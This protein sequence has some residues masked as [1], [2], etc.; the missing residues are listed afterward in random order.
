VVCAAHAWTPLQSSDGTELSWPAEAWPLTLA[1]AGATWSRAA[2]AWTQA[3]DVGFAPAADGLVSLRRIEDADEWADVVGDPGL[4]AFTL[5]TAEGG[6]LLDADVVLNAARFRFA[7]PPEPRAQ[8]T[9]TVLLHE[10]GHVLGLGHSCGDG[11]APGCFGL[12]ADDPRFTAV[13]FPSI[14]PGELRAPGADDVEGLTAQVDYPLEV[15]RP[16][17]TAVEA[18][19]PGRWRI[20]VAGGHLL[21]VRR[22]DALVRA[23][24]VADADGV[25]VRTG[26]AGPLTLE[27]WS[28]A[29]QGWVGVDALEPAAVGLDAAGVGAEATDPVPS[30][31]GDDGCAATGVAASAML[32][33]AL[34]V[35]RRE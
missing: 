35:R 32:W 5:V 34:A 6:V 12:D 26:D 2:A 20:E 33:L 10:L 21:R 17:V 22:G 11:G 19:G 15:D 27:V 16:V 7:D 31:G 28:A 1:E 29:G 24:L 23:T 4:V 18:L 9:E 3:A 8:A 30:D 25:D 13:M 14:G